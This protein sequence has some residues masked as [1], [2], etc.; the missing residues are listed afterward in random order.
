M[1]NYQLSKLAS[2]PVI[3][4]VILQTIIMTAF[5]IFSFILVRDQPWFEMF[6][7]NKNESNSYNTTSYE[8]TTIFSLSIMQYLI[9]VVI[10]SIGKPYRE[11]IYKNTALC[12]CLISLI[13]LNMSIIIYPPSF[14]ADFID[15]K[16]I[17][18][19]FKIKIV[20]LQVINF[21]IWYISE[22]LINFLDQ[23]FR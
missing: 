17:P 1:I 19:N 12:V 9:S 22:C 14:L 21:A 16:Y 23:S 4:S 20:F 8:G 2:F 15:L 18:W 10:F 5:Q 6:M 13:A 3:F 7:P 11:P